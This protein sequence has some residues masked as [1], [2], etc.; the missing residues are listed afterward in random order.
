MLIG[1]RDRLIRN[2]TRL[3]NAFRGYDAE[4]GLTAARGMC[5]IEPLLDVSR[6]IRCFRI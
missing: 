2:R 1:L 5:K 4:F 6:Q 3:A